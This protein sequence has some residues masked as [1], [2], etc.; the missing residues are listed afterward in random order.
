VKN[1]RYKINGEFVI[2]PKMSKKEMKAHRKEYNR[3]WRNANPEK[4]AANK[5][6]YWDYKNKM[7]NKI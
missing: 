1:A 5:K 4:V 3:Q 6:R 7:E 2:L